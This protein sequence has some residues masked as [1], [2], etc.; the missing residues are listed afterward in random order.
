MQT[1]KLN[2]MGDLYQRR[3]VSADIGSRAIARIIDWVIVTSFS[4]AIVAIV[5]ELSELLPRG[6]STAA[7]ISAALFSIPY[8]VA[9][10]TEFGA[11]PGKMI[12]SLMV[13]TTEGGPIS[14]GR[15]FARGFSELL[16]GL[17]C[18]VG[19]FMAALDPQR[20]A[21]HDRMCN[22]RVVQRP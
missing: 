14:T 8:S 12:F 16:S 21:L 15:A 13:V 11:T 18:Y 6:L 9:F 2:L 5:R 4:W 1:R 20:R 10:L 19:Y 3:L 7:I 17:A 22:T